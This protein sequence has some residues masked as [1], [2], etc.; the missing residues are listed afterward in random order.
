MMQSGLYAPGEAP[1]DKGGWGNGWEFS[2][3]CPKWVKGDK[4]GGV[5]ASDQK[6]NMEVLMPHSGVLW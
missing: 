3:E 5:G 1:I 2:Q 4:A 6:I